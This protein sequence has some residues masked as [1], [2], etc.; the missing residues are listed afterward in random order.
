LGGPGSNGEIIITYT[1]VTVPEP[2]TLTLLAAGALG[3]IGYAWRRRAA[4][5]KHSGLIE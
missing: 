5:Q 3:L 4:W 1:Q 2:S